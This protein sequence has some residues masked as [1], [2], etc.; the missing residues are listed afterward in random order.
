[1]LEALGWKE[2]GREGKVHPRVRQTDDLPNALRRRMEQMEQIQRGLIGYCH[3]VS[4]LLQVPGAADYRPNQHDRTN[5]YDYIWRRDS[6]WPIA[7]LMEALVALDAMHLLP[8]A[9]RGT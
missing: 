8:L 2:F 7:V 4:I 5:F 6:G 9:F 1:M 3:A